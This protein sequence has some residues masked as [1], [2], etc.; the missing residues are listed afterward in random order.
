MKFSGAYSPTSFK[1]GRIGLSPPPQMTAEKLKQFQ[2]IAEKSG[3]P[4]YSD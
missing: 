2:S 1:A 3:Q 4:D